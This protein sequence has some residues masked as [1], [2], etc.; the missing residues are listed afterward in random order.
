MKKLLIVGGVMGIAWW[1]YKKNALP[2]E[3]ADAISKAK[4]VGENILNQAQQAATSV[5]SI[6][7]ATLTP[8][9]KADLNTVAKIYVR[10]MDEAP[11]STITEPKTAA[12]KVTS[13]QTFVAPTMIPGH[14]VTKD[15]LAGLR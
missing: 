11:P 8:P 4:A 1:L 10:N 5:P 7:P 15:L 12:Q 2:A 9:T 6:V 13:K 3:A 14:A